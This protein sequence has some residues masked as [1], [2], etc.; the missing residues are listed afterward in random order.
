MRDFQGVKVLRGVTHVVAPRDPERGL[1]LSEAELP[2]GGGVGDILAAHVTRGLADVQ[3][4]AASF[5][6][7]RDDRACGAFAR[8]LAQRPR[9]VDVSTQLATALYTIA[10][11]DERVTDGNLAVLQCEALDGDGGTVRFPAVLKLDPSAT[12]KEI[13]DTDPDTGKPRIRYEVDPKS[14]PSK[15]E[16]VQKCVFVR[17]VDDSADYEMLVVDRQRRGE[18]LSRFWVQDFLGAESVLDAPERTRRLYRS[19][20][21]ARNDA[22]P[23]LNADQLA[24]LD[25]VIDGAVAQASVDLDNLVA[26]LPV[27]DP[28]RQRINAAVSRQLPDRQFDLDPVVAAEYVRRRSYR[29]DN[30]LRISV[31]GDQVNMIKVD[32]VDPDDTSETRLR[33]VSFETRIWK[34]V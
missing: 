19:L 1:R 20:K 15:N 9:L 17:V 12:L 6:D 7:R 26:A 18:T 5:T 28:V 16:R 30:D 11:A 4:K 33:R 3:A 25:Q 24:A 32:D 10:E 34:E 14:L 27:P 13:E 29:A 22:A 31:R 8:L 23:D 2:L 21:R